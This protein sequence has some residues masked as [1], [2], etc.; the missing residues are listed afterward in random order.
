MRRAAVQNPDALVQEIERLRARLDSFQLNINIAWKERDG[1]REA[2][3]QV[4]TGG[5]REL[6]DSPTNECRC[7][8]GIARAALEAK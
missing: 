1:L 2:L 5:H 6:C 4:A 7:H 3:E 8:I